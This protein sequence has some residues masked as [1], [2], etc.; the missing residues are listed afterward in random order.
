GW[1]ARCRRA[2]CRGSRARRRAASGARRDR[3]S[4]RDCG[5]GRA[6]GRAPWSCLLGG[7]APVCQRIAPIAATMQGFPEPLEMVLPLPAPAART[8]MHTRRVTYQGFRRD[9]GLWD[10]E[11]ELHDSKPFEFDLRGEG[12]WAPGEP[13][14]HM[15]L[16][17]SFDDAMVIRAIDVALDAVPHGTCPQVLPNMQS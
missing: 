17:V 13:V 5:R 11:G 15:H 10:V 1:R 7:V 9:D 4:G 14:H 12:R 6:D 16:R 8:P 2:G 3:V